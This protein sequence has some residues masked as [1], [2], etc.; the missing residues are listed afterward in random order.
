MMIVCSD[1]AVM[2]VP[3]WIWMV[4]CLDNRR[5]WCWTDDETRFDN[6]VVQIHC[7]KMPSRVRIRAYICI[8][9]WVCAAGHMRIRGYECTR[10]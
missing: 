2:V 8:C 6:V 9:V 10:A 4:Q 5:E 7:P 1:G 3:I